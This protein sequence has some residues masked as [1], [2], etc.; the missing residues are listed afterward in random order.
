MAGKIHAEDGREGAPAVVSWVTF[1]AF[2]IDAGAT[3]TIPIREA[4]DTGKVPLRLVVDRATDRGFPGA[5]GVVIRVAIA[6]GPLDALGAAALVNRV[7]VVIVHALPT[8]TAYAQT[9]PVPAAVVSMGHIID[10]I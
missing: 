7:A 6:T 4:P 10:V 8:A 2:E 5:T 9:P 1:S 3:R